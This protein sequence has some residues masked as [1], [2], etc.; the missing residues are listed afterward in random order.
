M[1]SSVAN[2]IYEIDD[3]RLNRIDPVA[4]RERQVGVTLKDENKP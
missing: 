2:P 4:D 3:A 1:Y